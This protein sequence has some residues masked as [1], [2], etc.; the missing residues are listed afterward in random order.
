MP[1]ARPSGPISRPSPRWLISSPPRP[2]WWALGMAP[3]DRFGTLSRPPP[4]LPPPAP[5]TRF[6]LEFPRRGRSTPLRSSLA[7]GGTLADS[8]PVCRPRKPHLTPPY[9]CVQDH[10]E[11]LEQFWPERFERR[12]GFWRPCLKEGMVRY[13]ACGDLHE[14][15]ARIRREKCGLERTL[16]FSC[17]RRYMCPSCHQKR[18][19]A[20]GEWVLTHVLPPLPY[21]HFPLSIPKILRRLFLRDRSLLAD[22]SRCGWQALKSVM[23]A[24]VPE[25]DPQ[26]VPLV[27]TQSFGEFAERFHPH[28]HIL[29]PY[30]AFYGKGLFGSPPPP[31]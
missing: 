18:S 27:A 30:G 21:R 29:A 28:L 10:Y 16:A 1:R 25:A 3:E 14:G 13:L 12:Y 24:A 4:S 8:A 31:P 9:Q 23:Q 11:A 15:F 6:A 2:C 5:G 7:P 20:F 19:V 17:K 26:P 22:L